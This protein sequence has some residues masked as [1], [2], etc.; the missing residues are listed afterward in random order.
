VA[1]SAD[2]RWLFLATASGGV[3]AVGPSGETYRVDVTLP[4]FD[5]LL[6]APTRR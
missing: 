1:W 5:A 3:D 4:R 2:G 6:V